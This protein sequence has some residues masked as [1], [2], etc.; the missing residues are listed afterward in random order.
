M[1][2][3]VLSKR[4][5]V[6]REGGEYLLAGYENLASDQVQRPE[7]ACEAK[8]SEYLTRRGERDLGAPSSQH[9]LHQ[10]HPAL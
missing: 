1:V 6:K 7:A 8:L 4:N 5:V 10:R 2:R 9:W 3:R